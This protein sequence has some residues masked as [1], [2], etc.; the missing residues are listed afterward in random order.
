MLSKSLI[1]LSVDGWGCVPF[2]LFT[3]GSLYGR[4]NEVNGEVLQ[5]VPCVHCYTQCP[6]PCSRP[7]PTHTSIGDSGHSWASL[8]QSLVGSLLLSH[9][10]WC[11]QGFVVT[12]KSLSLQSCVSSG[13][14]M[15][16]LIA[17]SSTTAYAIHRSAAPR[18][19]ALR[20]STADLY[21]HSRHSNTVLAQSLL[22]LLFPGAHKV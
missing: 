13:G 2:L 8:G 22:G 19:R 14:S 6:Q 12:F 10:S 16:G 18:A 7:P 20:Q 5:K 4:G 9:G 17:T 21:L 1:Q 15:V 3:R 11:A